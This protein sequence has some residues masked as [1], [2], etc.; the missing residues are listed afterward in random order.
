MTHHLPPASQA[1]ARGVVGG[2]NDNGEG[3]Q[4]KRMGDREHHH[5]HHYEHLLAGWR[6]R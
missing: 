5:H 1:T 6:G 2:W 3:R 4:Q